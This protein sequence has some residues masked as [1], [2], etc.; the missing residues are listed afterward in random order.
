MGVDFDQNEGRRKRRRPSPPAPARGSKNTEQTRP[1]ISP[2][3]I[4]SDDILIGEGTLLGN[5]QQSLVSK[6]DGVEVVN[7]TAETAYESVTDVSHQVSS[8]AANGIVSTEKDLGQPTC[9]SLVEMVPATP[10]KRMLRVRPDGKL[11]SPVSVNSP[12]ETKS[13]RGRKPK[14]ADLAP[15]QLI[16]VLKYG[17]SSVSQ[18]SQGQQINNIFSGA[19]RCSSFTKTRPSRHT[20]PTK[21]THPFFLGGN[22]PRSGQSPTRLENTERLAKTDER[23]AQRQTNPGTPKRTRVISKPADIPDRV[24]TVCTFG[25]NKFDSEHAQISR[26]PGAKNPV[27]PPA[28]MV[29]VGRAEVAYGMVSNAPRHSSTLNSS[30]K[31]KGTVV[32]VS[33]EEDIMGPSVMLVQQRHN[34]IRAGQ[35]VTGS[36]CQELGR[37]VRRLLTGRQLQHEARQRLAYDPDLILS[38]DLVDELS[39]SQPLRQAAH[40]ALRN[41]YEQ[42]RTSLTAFDKFECETQEWVLK[43]APKNAEDVLQ[44]SRDVCLLRDWLRSLTIKSGDDKTLNGGKKRESSTFSMKRIKKRRRR[45]VEEIDDFVAYSDD[46]AS[47]MDEITDPEDVQPVNELLKRSVIRTGDSNINSDTLNQSTNAVVVSGP[48]G[49]GKTAAIMAVAEELGFEV[50]EINSGSRRSGR[51]VLD[52]VGDMTRNHLVKHNAADEANEIRS[53]AG[54]EALADERLKQDLASGRQGTMNNFFKSN[55]L[56]KRKKEAKAPKVVP[57]ADERPK[58]KRQQN[59]KQSLI[60]LEEVD[61]LFEEDK[62][63]WVTTLDMILQSKRPIIMTCTDESLLPLEDILLH[64]IFRFGRPAEQLAVDYLLLLACNEGHLISRDAI[65]ALYQAKG[66]DLRASIAE[67]SLYCQ[68]AVGDTKGGLE[69]MLIR[70]PESKKQEQTSESTRVVSDGTYHCGMGW[71]CGGVDQPQ[72]ESTIADESQLLAEA[73]YGWNI[74]IATFEDF[75]MAPILA[76]S[77]ESSRSENFEALMHYE[78][79]F[80][81]LSAADIIPAIVSREPS[82]L[83]MDATRPEMTEK[84]RMNYVEGFAVLQADPIV[85]STGVTNSLVFTLK[86]CSR[87]LLGRG[88]LTEQQIIAMIPNAVQQRRLSLP[89]TKSNILPSLDPIAR[90]QKA[91]LGIPK[92]PQITSFDGPLSTITTDLAPYVRSIVSYDLRLEEQRWQLS[93]L[94]SRPGKDGG[95]VRTT[96]ASRAALEGGN[97]ESTRRERWFPNSTNFDAVLRTGG[98]G[99]QDVLLERMAAGGSRELAIDAV[100]GEAAPPSS[101]GSMTESGA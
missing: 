88:D 58:L 6:K 62:Q 36:G 13:K 51:D 101:L 49:C 86:A 28:E 66:S 83:I 75:C 80:D 74:D 90:S 43:Y 20:Q 39:N 91:V 53:D 100:G 14:K 70:S 22:A 55:G 2:R 24:A 78:N 27:W 31:L 23:L 3:A 1:A 46:D 68:M 79:G 97:K 17:S 45:K 38:A 71:L 63:F 92:G 64:A 87:R 69:W 5:R 12:K 76:D 85:D 9:Q 67:L 72:R 26:F 77:A 65:V 56:T 18:V 16:V 47:Q 10:P 4:C 94:L 11:G 98:F 96:R 50:F 95:K 89:M 57:K 41:A 35:P 29:H 93:A 37:P 25:P 30:R 60:L 52:K 33:R 8:K 54:E 59:H 81:A 34:E 44:H 82:M 19:A 48:H 99:W 21:P 15:K 73:W 7:E 84:S 40:A 61:V 42:I 32:L